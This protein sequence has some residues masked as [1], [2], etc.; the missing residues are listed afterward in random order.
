[1]AD[2]LNILF[3]IAAL[4]GLIY[5]AG[6]V[7]LG[8]WFGWY[9]LVTGGP[10]RWRGAALVV[11]GLLVFCCS[12]YC[13]KG[14]LTEAVVLGMQREAAGASVL[15]HPEGLADRSLRPS[16]CCAFT[17]NPACVA[18][19]S[20]APG[21]LWEGAKPTPPTMATT[22]HPY[23]HC[24]Y[25]KRETIASNKHQRYERRAWTLFPTTRAF[26]CP[27]CRARGWNDEHAAIRVKVRAEMQREQFGQWLD[28]NDAQ[29]AERTNTPATA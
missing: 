15:A 22:T 27:D 21:G 17:A 3:V 1:M 28:A 10:D 23:R 11:G 14:V 5:G 6:M 20:A 9:D 2:L 12:A 25:C 26:C 8:L 7:L 4:L 19:A 16:P 24:D 13:L 18:S 29:D